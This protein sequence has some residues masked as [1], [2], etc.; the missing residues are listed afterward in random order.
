MK[1]IQFLDAQTGLW[2]SSFEKAL[3]FYQKL[4]FIPVFQNEE[5]H[6]VVKKDKITLH[7]STIEGQLGG[8]Q[9]IV[10]QVDKLYQFVQIE[11]MPIVYEIDDRP[12]GNR[13][14]TIADPDGNQLTFSQR[15]RRT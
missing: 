6:L 10:N 5:I 3:P 9:I 12:W 8:L 11:K 2:V 4:G 15:L 13:D 1:D 7:L 14:F